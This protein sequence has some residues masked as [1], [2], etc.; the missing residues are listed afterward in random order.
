[1]SAGATTV[2]LVGRAADAVSDPEGLK[3][4]RR[5]TRRITYAEL[6]AGMLGAIDVFVLLWFVLPTPDTDTDRT[7]MFVVNLTALVGV[8]AVTG[9]MGVLIGKRLARP[10]R[11]WLAA[12]RPPTDRERALVLR[13]PLQCATLDAIAWTASAF[14]FFGLNSIWS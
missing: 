6:I 9:I 3:L 10:I 14:F 8:V 1:M 12:G 4:F 11:E 5:V 13:Q 2:P 7:T